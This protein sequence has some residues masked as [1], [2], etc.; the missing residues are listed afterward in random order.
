M[1]IA[2]VVV[3][4]G[5]S[6]RASRSPSVLLQDE[7][8]WTPRGYG[9]RP[10]GYGEEYPAWYPGMFP[11][12]PTQEAAALAYAPEFVPYLRY[13]DYLQNVLDAKLDAKRAERDRLAS[14][15]YTAAADR[16][17]C[18]YVRARV[19]EGVIGCVH[20]DERVLRFHVPLFPFQCASAA[21]L[22][23]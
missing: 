23:G 18:T 4:V 8:L 13:K 22:A 16:C 7:A 14:E 17:L 5:L 2:C 11:I 15:V 3:C 12:P 21:G 1:A 19:C 6:E 9:Y 10:Q 20:A